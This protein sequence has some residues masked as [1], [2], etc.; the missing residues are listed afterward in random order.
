M[1]SNYLAAGSPGDT[2]TYERFNTSQFTW[3]LS[4]INTGTNDGRMKLGNSSEWIVYDV[5]SNVITVYETHDGIINP[6]LVF[7]ASAQT[8]QMITVSGEELLFLTAPSITVQAGTFSDVLG[9]VW[10]DSEFG[11]NTFNT[12]LALGSAIT[13]AVT[14]VDFYVS[15]VGLVK[16]MGVEAATGIIDG[17][18]ELVGTAASSAATFNYSGTLK[19]IFVDD[20]TGTYSGA[21][22]G[23]TYSGEFSAG[24]SVSDGIPVLPCLNDECEYEFFGPGITTSISDDVMSETGTGSLIAISNQYDLENDDAAFINVLPGI[25]WPVGTLLDSW[26]GDSWLDSGMR[27]FLGFFSLDTSLYSSLAYQPSPP[28]LTNTD[29]AIFTI[30]ETDAQGGTT[31]L[32][33]GT[34]NSVTVMPVNI[35]GTVRTSDGTDICAM[36]LASGQFIFSCNPNGVFSL[37]GLPREKNG[38]V[39]RQVYADGFFPKIDILAGSSDDAVVMNRSGTCPSYNLPNDHAV[40]PGSAGKRINITGNVLLQDSQ[41][42]ICAMVLANGKHMFSCDGTGSYALNIPLDNNGQFKLQ[43]YADGFAPT[44]QTFDEFSAANDVRM[45]RAAECQ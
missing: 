4:A 2:W 7:P 15:G 14:D 11:P 37:P 8:G 38:T 19:H 1:P 43:V 25:S 33:L 39:K 29:L 31:F 32:A 42:P 13:A 28:E 23:D 20:G 34:L 9:L 10:L 41:T 45:A 44:I 36:V 5:V 40:V 17:G 3:A 27:I 21:E 24:S 30:E 16:Q 35:N 26:G 6:P 18:F 12:Q 22:I